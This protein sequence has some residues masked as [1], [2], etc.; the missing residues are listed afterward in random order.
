M[1]MEYSIV[2]YDETL[3]QQPPTSV[4]LRIE[5]DLEIL[6]SEVPRVTCGK[7]WSMVPKSP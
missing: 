3:I 4:G 5:K 2:Q 1:M 6:L 7:R